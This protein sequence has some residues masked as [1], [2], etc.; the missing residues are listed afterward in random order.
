MNGLTRIRSTLATAGM[1]VYE[2][3]QARACAAPYVVVRDMGTYPY[4]GNN[5]TGYTLAVVNV[6]VPMAGY[7]QLQTLIAQ[8]QTLLKP[9]ETQVEPTGNIGPDLIEEDYQAHSKSLEYRINR[10]L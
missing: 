8:V 9:L 7:S 1:L 5:K 10:T 2:Q 3:A 6:Y 4:A